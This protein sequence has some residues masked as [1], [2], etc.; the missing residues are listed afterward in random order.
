MLI[1]NHSLPEDLRVLYEA[2]A[3]TS[4]GYTVLAICAGR[5]GQS[6]HETIKNID[7]FR[8]PSIQFNDSIHFH[9][10]LLGYIVEFG[11]SLVAMFFIS[12]RLLIKPGFDIIHVGNPPDI[13]VLIW[14]FFK[15]IGKRIV[16]D[17]HDMDPE[18]YNAKFHDNGNPL[19][20][21][22]LLWF[23]KLS[24][25]FA[26]H[27]ITTN[28][29][30]KDIL[31]KRHQIDEEKISIVRNG[32]LTSFV[33]EKQIN[34][35]QQ[36]GK[37][38]LV[39]AG[40]I[41]HQDGVDH[42]IRALHHIVFC[43]NRIDFKCVIIG[44]GDAYPYITSLAEELKLTNFL[45]FP[46]WISHTLVRQYLNTADI[47][48]APEPSNPLNDCTTVIKMM[49]YMASAKPIVAFDLPEHRVTVQDGAAFARPNDDQDLAE[50]IISLMD[51]SDRRRE[52]GQMNLERLENYL[53]WSYQAK[54][55]IDAY[56]YLN[57]R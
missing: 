31:M 16:F 52:M 41:G 19:I 45:I 32:P 29:S 35:L 54:N 24:C 46:G 8:F 30:Q 4:N 47:C 13:L 44:N 14:V 57:N 38:I 1:Q 11:W 50:K 37:T 55:L 10:G 6:R 7:V 40:V 27:I 42:L 48:I 15:I 2:L 20:Y 26:D 56:K 28:Q 39:Y 9:N 51:D 21:S 22:I 53:L 43:F 5:Q 25:K 17:Q 36:D 33:N 18:L 34:E 49:E 12:L 23:E 3:L